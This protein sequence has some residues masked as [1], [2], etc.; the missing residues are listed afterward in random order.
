MNNPFR[1]GEVVQTISFFFYF[2]VKL[3]FS[4]VR[5]KKKLIK[6]AISFMS[7]KVHFGI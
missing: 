5:Q 6:P 1:I 4:A 7:P 2:G 3:S